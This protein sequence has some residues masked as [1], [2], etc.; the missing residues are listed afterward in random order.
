METSIQ[1][2]TELQ[3]IIAKI[4]SNI[5]NDSSKLL[6]YIAGKVVFPSIIKNFKEEGRPK[7]QGLA[8]RTQ[9]E[10]AAEGYGAEHPILFREGELFRNATTKDGVMYDLGKHKLTMSPFLAKAE[11][12]HYGRGR[13]PARPFFYLQEEDDGKASI[14]TGIFISKEIQRICKT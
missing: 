2:L 6:D 10:R 4:K 1:G 14:E 13:V 12:L 3:M 8:Q 9:L 7:W 11:I 5:L